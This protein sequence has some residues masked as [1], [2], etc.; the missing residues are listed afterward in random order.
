MGGLARAGRGAAWLPVAALLV[1]CGGG[2]SSEDRSRPPS[3]QLSGDV[4]SGSA[5][6][7]TIAEFV[8][9]NP[10]PPAANVDGMW[11]PVYP[12]PLISVHSALLPDGRVMT[13]G[14]DLTGLQT[15][16]AK[17]DIWDSTGAPDLGHLTLDNT[18]GTDIFC[19]SQV[20]L[21]QSGNLFIAGGDVWTGTQT[22]NGPNNNS[23]LYDSASMSLTRGINMNRSRWYSSSITLINGETYIQSGSGGSDRPEIRGLDGSFRLMSG[24]NTSAIGSSFPRNFVAPDGRVFGY[25]PGNGQMYRVDTS[26]SGAIT[27]LVS[28]NTAYSGG[29]YSS[30]AMYRPGQILQ[31]GG[32][33]N[34]A[35]TI[36]I[37]GTI[38]VVAQTQTMSSTRAWVN[39]TVLA[40]GKVVA[41]SGSAVQGEATGYNNIAEIWTPPPGSGAGRG[42]AEDAPYH[43]NALAAD[44][45]VLVSGGARSPTVAD[46][47]PEQEQPERRDL[48]PPYLFTGLVSA[49][50]A[51]VAKR[52]LDRHRQDLRP[53]CRRR[54]EREPRHAGQ[55][56]FDDAQLQHGP[57][58]PRPDVQ[59]ERVARRRAGAD[60][61]R[62]CAARVLPAVRVQRSR[63]AV[64]RQDRPHGHREQPEPRHQPGAHQPGRTD[65]HRRCAHRPRAERER[66]ERRCA[67]LR[68]DRPAARPGN[69]YEQWPHHRHPDDCGQ[70]QRRRL[71]DRRHQQRDRRVRLDDAGR[72]AAGS[73]HPAGAGLRRHQRRR[74]L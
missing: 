33:S 22:T 62:R 58:L 7:M 30:A 70:L 17:Y 40:D 18:T 1:S 9:P 46:H 49:R 6:R 11:S 2:D 64:G 27:M 37:T 14:S 13:Y 44:A 71:G 41:T 23:N 54:G 26:G 69:R 8:P 56:R 59:R 60:A 50:R 28:F 51:A 48:Y 45:S 12:W 47:R 25:D 67:E 61:R 10:I 68:R 74:E 55:D 24:I 39:A 52:R 5:K 32:T 65:Q 57:A 35:Y 42:R 19:S 15:G 21:P 43:S 63:R 72:D 53:G 38:P 34:G 73:R 36:D 20:L 3:T 16:H 29:W 4:S 66:P 31:I